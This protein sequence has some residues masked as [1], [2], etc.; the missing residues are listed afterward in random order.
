MGIPPHPTTT[1]KKHNTLF[2]INKIYS[3]YNTLGG[4]HSV[5]K[6]FQKQFT[7]HLFHWPKYSRAHSGRAALSTAED[8]NKPRTVQIQAIARY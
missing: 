4:K 5:T 7:K 1:T 2:K 8:G 3:V 6:T